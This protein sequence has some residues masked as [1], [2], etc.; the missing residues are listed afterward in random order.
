MHHDHS[1]CHL[2]VEPGFDARHRGHGHDR[3]QTGELL[4]SRRGL[5]EN[6]RRNLRSCVERQH[7]AD[8]PAQ[9]VQPVFEPGHD[10][11]VATP[12]PDSPEQIRVILIVHA[13]TDVHLR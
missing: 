8:D 11:K 13:A 3:D 5:S 1:N 2:A 4:R 10:T 9:R 7:T 12:T 6:R